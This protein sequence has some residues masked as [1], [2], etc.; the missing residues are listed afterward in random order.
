MRIFWIHSVSL[1]CGQPRFVRVGAE[2]I[3]NAS[4]VL[5]ERSGL[6]DGGEDWPENT[7]P[8]DA[9]VEGAGPEGRYVECG[10]NEGVDDGMEGFGIS[11]TKSGVWVRGK[12]RE[13]N[14]AYVA[15]S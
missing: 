15:P 5:A 4:C 3:G 13:K 11:P 12:Q 2:R 9:G 10:R 8:A 6:G 7:E 14:T 1:S